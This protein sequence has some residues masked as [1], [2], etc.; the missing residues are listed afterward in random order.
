MLDRGTVLDPS[1]DVSLRQGTARVTEK[2]KAMATRR[3]GDGTSRALLRIALLREM[4][5]LV[6]RQSNGSCGLERLEVKI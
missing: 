3:G 5:V 2:T 4:R 1:P 6:N